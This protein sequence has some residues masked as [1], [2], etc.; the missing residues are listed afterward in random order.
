MIFSSLFF[1]CV[2]FPLFLFLYFRADSIDTQNRTL[3]IF[4]LLFYCWGGFRYL[5]LLLIMTGLGFLSGRLMDRKQAGR[6]RKLILIFS[7]AAFLAVL[8]FFKYTGFFL[9]T[10]GTLF[11]QDWDFFRIALPLGISFYTFKLIS[12]VADVYTEK[13]RPAD[14]YLDL[15]LYTSIF[16]QSVS[17]PIERYTDMAP[18]IHQR[19]ATLK[20]LVNGLTRFCIGLGKK[21]VLADHCGALAATL[22]PLSSEIKTVPVTGVWLGSVCYMLQ[23]Y[24]DFSA[25]S[26]MSLGL[27]QMV[28]FQYKENF[29]YP[30]IAVSIKDFWRRWHI[31]LSSFFR[32]YVYIPLGGNRCSARRIMLNLLAVWALTGLWHGASWNYILW[33]LYFF[34]FITLENRYGTKEGKK[35]PA[36]VGHIYTLLVVFFGWIL[37]RFE[38]FGQLGMAFKGLIGLNGN[39]FSSAAVGVV[40]K[41]NVFFLIIA[42]LACTPLVRDRAQLLNKQLNKRYKNVSKA[43]LLRIAVCI[44]MIAI[45]VFALIGNSYTPFLYNQF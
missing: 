25:Y 43:M 16:H 2:F 34:V 11:R 28:G 7:V 22:L 30:Y 40:L 9:R 15:L 17:G 39:A 1:L 18:Q 45:S 24:L 5:I 42:V 26:D 27:G 8:G 33:G 3:L 12:Y 29:N 38:D 4:S 41:N 20:N 13:C 10:A 37:F 32:D 44:L 14:R 21:A 36:F 35:F 31:S 19:K 23:L 6:E